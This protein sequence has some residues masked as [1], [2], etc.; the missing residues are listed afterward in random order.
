MGAWHE[1]GRNKD[2]MLKYPADEVQWKKIDAKYKNFGEKPRNVI[3]GLNTDRT[4]PFG[5]MISKHN[6]WLVLSFILKFIY[7][8]TN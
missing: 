3:F 2:K 1:D 5:N 6:T 7:F 4:N 8:Y